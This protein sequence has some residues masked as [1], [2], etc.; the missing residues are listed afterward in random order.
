MPIQ[1]LNDIL[2]DVNSYVDLEAKLPV[3]DELTTRQNYAN[4]AI[5]D[6]ADIGQLDEFSSIYEVDSATDSAITLPTGFREFESSPK[7]LVG[8]TWVNY[9]EIDP[10]ERYNMSS[11]EKYCYITGN[12]AIGYMANFNGLE[13]NCT[14]S[15][16]YQSFPTGFPTLTS[17]CELRDSSYVTTAIE[18]YVLQARGDDRFPYVDALKEKKLKNM[19]GRGMKSPGGQVRVSPMGFRNPLG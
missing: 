8:G 7:Q 9:D 6:A 14:L 3:G 12:P 11:G 16:T 18:S 5:R 17:K 13:A 15:F 2:I 1:T 4:R 19:F 10:K